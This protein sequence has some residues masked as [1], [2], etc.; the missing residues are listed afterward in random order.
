M[1]CLNDEIPAGATAGQIGRILGIT[2]RVV[3]GRKADGRLPVLPGGRVDLHRLVRL[4]AAAAAEQRSGAA[5]AG[6]KPPPAEAFDAG[7]RAAAATTAH[8]VLAAIT[9]LEPGEDAGK[10][11]AQALAEALD[12]LGVP[13]GEEPPPARLVALA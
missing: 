5:P 8:L 3:A 13:P 11:A 9:G 4:G 7:M 10:A 1:A 6:A 12:M 2:E